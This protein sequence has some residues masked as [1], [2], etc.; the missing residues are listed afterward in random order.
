MDAG[1]VEHEEGADGRDDDAD[2]GVALVGRD[3]AEEEA[4]RKERAAPEQRPR[5]AAAVL[6]P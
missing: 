5:R 2:A 1:G 3:T 6:K 4:E